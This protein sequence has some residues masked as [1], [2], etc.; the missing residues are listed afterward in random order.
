MYLANLDS[1]TGKKE[2]NEAVREIVHNNGSIVDRKDEDGYDHSHKSDPKE[3]QESRKT[4]TNVKET[5]N[6]IHVQNTEKD[7]SGEA[8][9]YQMKNHAKT[10]GADILLCK[11]CGKYFRYSEMITHVQYCR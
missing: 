10:S 11:Q 3:V 8:T 7:D 1:V 2:K 9:V 4:N 6:W 5:L